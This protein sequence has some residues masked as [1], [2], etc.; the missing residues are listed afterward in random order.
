M[1]K[2][3][4]CLVFAAALL[5]ACQVSDID[6]DN[7]KDTVPSDAVF[8]LKAEIPSTKTTYTPPRKVEWD[9][10]DELS[11]LV[12]EDGKFTGL[13]MQK[14]AGSDVFYTENYELPE[15]AEALFV[16]YP[17]SAALTAVDGGSFDAPAVIGGPAGEPLTQNGIA[18]NAGAHIDGPLYGCIGDLQASDLSV[19]MQH[20]TTVIEVIVKNEETA[21][22]E[23]TEVSLTNDA[24]QNL[25]GEFYVNPETGVLTPGTNVSTSA[26]LKAENA[27]IEAGATASFYFETAPFSLEAG[28][29]LTV[30]VTAGGKA[31]AFEKVMPEAADF[32]PGTRNWTNVTLT[33][34]SGDL[35][36]NET[37]VLFDFFTNPDPEAVTLSAV[38][39]P[40]GAT[41]LSW[42]TSDQYVVRVSDGV[43]TPVGHGVATVTAKADDAAG[44][45][46]TC[47]VKVN[48]V[49]D[50]NYGNGDSYYDKLYLP[51][52]ITVQT[53]EGSVTQT[54][55]DRNLGASRVA[56]AADDHL[57]YGSHFQWSRKADGHEQVSWTSANRGTHPNINA[58]QTLKLSRTEPETNEFIKVATNTEDWAATDGINDMYGL[59]GG[60]RTPSF[61][62]SCGDAAQANNPC[63]EGYR[64]PSS[65]EIYLM[66]ETMLG[67][68]THLTA[69]G[70][71]AVPGIAETLASS[72]LRISLCGYTQATGNST[73]T[74]A[75]RT[76]QSGY[77]CNTSGTSEANGQARRIHI[78]A[79]TETIT[80]SVTSRATGYAVRC[81]RD[82]AL[83]TVSL[84]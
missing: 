17:Y 8:E 18:E 30:S 58:S 61:A 51:V 29:K 73:A 70:S 32:L 15:T 12:Y 74:A 67:L 50:L 77:W 38:A 33:S 16:L 44:S 7:D 43:L 68:E 78:I 1:K 35:A 42:T 57:S 56:E 21:A 2:S 9:A 75:G 69:S 39:I 36:L 37:E 20:T 3:F 81:I 45:E 83:P 27:V 47:T 72:P 41:S 54:W 64:V 79:G 48:G 24:G 23:V 34:P 60:S 59:W 6:R 52:N 76:N 62:A 71:L 66:F 82:T 11:V 84:E 25:T 65:D 31:S 10:D 13:K 40:E 80:T 5:A 55:L 46:A 49:K 22:V 53:D 28:R 19:P 14:R 63:P 4:Y 26:V